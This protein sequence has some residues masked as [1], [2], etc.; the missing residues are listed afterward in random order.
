MEQGE[1]AQLLCSNN[2]LSL[3]QNLYMCQQDK[4]KMN[5]KTQPRWSKFLPQ[6]LLGMKHRAWEIFMFWKYWK[7]NLKYCSLFY[8]A[9][10]LSPVWN[11]YHFINNLRV[12]NFLFQ[13]SVKEG[14]QW[15][16]VEATKRITSLHLN[17]PFSGNYHLHYFIFQPSWLIKR[18]A[19]HFYT[20]PFMWFMLPRK[21]LLLK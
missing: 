10:F 5:I 20:A 4:I 19:V 14:F 7:C 18:Y 21:K 3:I 2:N 11:R 6:V 9:I 15:N 13:P 1:P 16:S 8:K 12:K 17:C